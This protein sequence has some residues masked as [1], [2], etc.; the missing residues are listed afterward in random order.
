[1][2]REKDGL[3]R[4]CFCGKIVQL[5]WSHFGWSYLFLLSNPK[6]SQKNAVFL[7]VYLFWC[8]R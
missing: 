4:I 6:R 8:S 1:M 3:K 2:L 5:W 7:S